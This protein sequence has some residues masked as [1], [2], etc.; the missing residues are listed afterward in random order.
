MCGDATEG[1]DVLKLIESDQPRL[2]FTDPPYDLKEFDYLKSFF[3]TQV[4]IEVLIINSD[5]GTIELLQRYKK[6]FRNFYIMKL[7]T[8]PI[9]YGNQPLMQ[10]RMISHFRKGKSN[11]LNLMDGFGTFHEIVLSKSG[12]TRQEKPISLPRRFITS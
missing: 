3:E 8:S 6:Y 10:H 12:L 11:F 1:N 5:L 4:D 2:I 7:H 9:G